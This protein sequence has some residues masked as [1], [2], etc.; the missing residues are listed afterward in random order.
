MEPTYVSFPN[1][2][3]AAVVEQIVL[4]DGYLISKERLQDISTKFNEVLSRG[5]SAE[6]LLKRCQ[7]KNHKLDARAIEKLKALLLLSEAGEMSED[8]IGVIVNSLVPISEDLV[9]IV[10]PVKGS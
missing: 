9:Q 5:I 7:D 10:N 6:D 3:G 2:A 8:V 1:L 4:R